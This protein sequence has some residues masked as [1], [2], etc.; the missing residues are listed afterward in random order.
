VSRVETPR[1]RA[2]A[3]LGSTLRSVLIA[4]AVGFPGA[5][6]AA[7]R[8]ERA[9]ARPAE[10]VAP[11]VLGALGGAAL[12]VLWLKLG[13]LLGLRHVARSQYRSEFVVGSMIAG[14]LLSLVAQGLWGSAGARVA[15][16]MGGRA[17]PRDL[18]IVWGAAAFPYVLSLVMLLPLDLAIVGE[19]TFTTEPLRDPVATGWA[20]LSIAL[21]T[22]LALWGAW[23]FVRGVGVAAELPLARAAAGAL[24]AALCFAGVIAFAIAGAV[25]MEASL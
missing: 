17:S 11:F 5:F 15:R 13:G 3:H 1:Q 19:D 4:P 24:I 14:A 23:L 25:M 20:A 22:V 7:D 16:L 21:A 18:R 9:G 10:G 12:F 8:R 6:K 2:S